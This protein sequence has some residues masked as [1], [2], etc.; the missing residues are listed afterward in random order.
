[1]LKITIESHRFNEPAVDWIMDILKFKQLPFI[2]KVLKK[3]DGIVIVEIIKKE[4][5]AD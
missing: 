1:M 2:K 3:R 5:D 4:I